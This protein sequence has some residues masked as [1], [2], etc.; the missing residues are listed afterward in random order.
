M[1]VYPIVGVGDEEDSAIV[2]VTRRGC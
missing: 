2:D 1:P